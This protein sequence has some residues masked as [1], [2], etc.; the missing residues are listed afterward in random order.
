MKGS[1]IRALAGVATAAA[2]VLTPTTAAQAHEDYD[3]YNLCPY[4]DAVCFWTGH[5]FHGKMSV[6]HDPGTGCDMA[7]AGHIGS[8]INRTDRD[9]WL[10][11]DR[12]C[13][14]W[15]GEVHPHSG[16]DDLWQD[17]RSWV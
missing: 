14:H 10:F 5:N 8:L 15:V 16:D 6:R 17:A 11:S 3:A 7:P 4:Y 2:L 13:Q 1:I 9:V 12:N